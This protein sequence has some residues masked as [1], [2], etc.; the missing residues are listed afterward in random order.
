[1]GVKRLNLARLSTVGAVALAGLLVRLFAFVSARPPRSRPG[2]APAPAP[3]P[4][5]LP[6]PPARRRP[7][8]LS[9]KGEALATVVRV[10][11]LKGHGQDLGR[12]VRRPARSRQGRARRGLRG[13]AGGD[14]QPGRPRSIRRSSAAPTRPTS[15]SWRCSAS[16]PA[17]PGAT[18]EK[19]PP[20]DPQYCHP[21]PADK[22]AP[23]PK[24]PTLHVR[25]DESRIATTTELMKAP[26]RVV[27]SEGMLVSP[28][29]LQQQDLYHERLL[30]ERIAALSP[31]RWGVVVGRDRRRRARLGSAA[32]HQVRRHPARRTL[33]G[34]RGRRSRVPADAADRRALPARRRPICEVFL[35]VPKEREGV[36]SVSIEQAAAGAAASS[37]KAARARFRAVT[38]P[39]RRPDRQRGRAGDGVRAPQRRRPVRRRAA[40]RL[41]TPS[42]SPRSCATA[43]APCWS[44]RRTSRPRCASTPRRS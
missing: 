31:Y 18:I 41:T 26:Q 27:W 21:A 28:Q 22:K 5:P 3:T 37:T 42:R 34:V 39:G 33:S 12:L 13:G 11:Q 15:R 24:D 8:N 32:R 7:L 43:P 16:R 19:L 14:D 23:A 17:P 38:A 30:D 4:E 2:R 10:Y 1:M 35:G 20:P 44:T 25:L 9:E 29:H 36:P 40:R 6:H